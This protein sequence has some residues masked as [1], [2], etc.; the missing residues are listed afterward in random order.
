L[1]SGLS[2]SETVILRDLLAAAG[3]AT[4]SDKDL[5]DLVGI[6]KSLT[7]ERGRIRTRHGDDL[8]DALP[9]VLSALE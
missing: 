5:E 6:W 9:Y 2:E 1:I 4:E 8:F 7:E 3:C